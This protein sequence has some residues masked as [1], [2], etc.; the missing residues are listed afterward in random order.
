[1]NGKGQERKK[2]RKK[3]EKKPPYKLIFQS[4]HLFH[5]LDPLHPKLVPPVRQQAWKYRID[6]NLWPLSLRKTSHKVQTSGF[7][8]RVPHCTATGGECGN[9]GRDEE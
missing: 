2:K 7:R 3:P 9:G 5:F 1:M 4:C 6:S 8:N